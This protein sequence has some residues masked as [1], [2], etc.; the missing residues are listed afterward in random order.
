M[1][2]DDILT[3]PLN[4][5]GKPGGAAGGELKQ[6]FIIGIRLAVQLH[7]GCFQVGRAIFQ[8]NENSLDCS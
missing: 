4:T 6:I 2:R 5:Q 7:G 8:I 1:P 3:W